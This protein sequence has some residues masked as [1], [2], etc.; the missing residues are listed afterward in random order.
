VRLG[1]TSEIYFQRKYWILLNR[2]WNRHKPVSETLIYYI[3]CRYTFEVLLTK[4]A[5][6]IDQSQKRQGMLKIYVVWIMINPK[7]I[8]LNQ[9]SL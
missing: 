9:R 7:V 2:C 3:Y 5:K 6:Y 1:S 4:L 8:L